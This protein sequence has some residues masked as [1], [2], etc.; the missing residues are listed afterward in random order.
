[1][2]VSVH[3]RV[4][5]RVSVCVCVCMLFARR[6]VWV[7][8][9]VCVCVCV[10][11]GHLV[12]TSLPHLHILFYGKCKWLYDYLYMGPGQKMGC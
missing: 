2:S 7:Y 1:M 4:C 6:C 5:E 3:A 12:L 9:C 10:C 8:V 11:V